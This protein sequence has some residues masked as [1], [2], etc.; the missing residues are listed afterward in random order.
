MRAEVLPHPLALRENVNQPLGVERR[1]EQHASRLEQVLDARQRVV[2]IGHVL[3]YVKERDGVE[4]RA[5]V[6]ERRQRRAIDV[7]AARAAT[8]A[9]SMPPFSYSSAASAPKLPSRTPISGTR[10]RAGSCR[11]SQWK[12]RWLV[13]SRAGCECD[14][15]AGASGCAC[16]RST[17]RTG[18][19]PSSSVN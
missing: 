13:R 16:A 9:G 14:S 2:R 19:V 11:R 6:D 15:Y 8:D 10:A 17:R 1:E 18:S 7:E 3:E 12:R 4:G 5:G